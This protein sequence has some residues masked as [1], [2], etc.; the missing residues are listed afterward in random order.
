MDDSEEEDVNV[1]PKARISELPPLPPSRPQSPLSFQIRNYQAD[2]LPD[3]ST[4]TSKSETSSV[5]ISP[6]S[7]SETPSSQSTDISILLSNLRHKFQ[8]SEQ[9][10]YAKLSQTH[11]TNL[12]D[13]RWSFVTNARG[14]TARMSAWQKKHI[15]GAGKSEGGRAAE[16]LDINIQEPEWW[17]SGCYAVPG[18]RFIVREGEWGSIIAFTLR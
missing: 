2:P 17:Q 6:T 14:A 4:P 3:V 7:A 5:T 1:T 9:T 11:D 18:S 12:N 13:V 10:L 16:D 15:A 8:Q